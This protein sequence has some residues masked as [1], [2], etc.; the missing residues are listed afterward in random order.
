MSDDGSP[1]S[2][3]AEQRASLI[4]YPSDIAVKAMGLADGDAVPGFQALVESLVRPLIEP[5][6]PTRIDVR[7]SSGGKYA[8][9]SVHFTVTSQ[10]QLEAIYSALHAEPRVLF[11]L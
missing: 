11:T 10:G 1:L 6:R 8:S 3:S 9:V 5:A 7:A 2:V 4:T